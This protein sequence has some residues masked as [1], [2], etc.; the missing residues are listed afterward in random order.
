V[1]GTSSATGSL[2]SFLW[3]AGSATDLGSCSPKDVNNRGQV[4]CS[5]S[6]PTIWENGSASARDTVRNVVALNDSGHVLSLGSLW[7]GPA[8]VAALQ[9]VGQGL[10]NLDDVIGSPTG[11]LY[12]QSYVFRQGQPTRILGFGRSVRALA[13]NDS[14]DVVGSS[15]DMSYAGHFSLIAFLARRGDDRGEKLRPDGR[16][17][18]PNDIAE[19]AVDINN[20]RHCVGSGSQGPFVWSDGKL[21]LLNQLISDQTWIVVSVKRINNRGQILGQGTNSTTGQSGAV[22]IDPP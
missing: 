1:V 5:A 18:M 10:N 8:N 16:L 15:E 2:Q 19:S 11:P 21:G 3:K 13:I 14:S 20:Q 17:Q 12:Q 7:R 4:L 22:L 6:G 9:T